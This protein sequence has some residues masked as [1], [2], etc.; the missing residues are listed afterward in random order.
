MN[1]NISLHILLILSSAFILILNRRSIN[2]LIN[3]NLLVFWFFCIVFQ[4][5]RIVFNS[6]QYS[7][8]GLL[9]TGILVL[10][11]IFMFILMSKYIKILSYEEF[12]DIVDRM[13]INY[14]C[15]ILAVYF[16]FKLYLITKYNLL[17]ANI[18]A[19]SEIIGAHYAEVLLDSLFVYPALGAFFLI[20][21][22]MVLN[23]K[24]YFKFLPVILCAN[25]ILF[26]SIIPGGAR[27]F[28]ASI[29]LF[30]ILLLFQQRQCKIYRPKLIFSIV[31]GTVLLWGISDGY[32]RIRG[33]FT[34]TQR[35]T[36]IHRIVDIY[37]LAVEPTA[38]YDQLGRNILERKSPY[39]L[40]Y[41]I[42]DH[43]RKTFQ[44][45]NGAVFI[46]SISNAIPR[47][48]I[49]DKDYLN[50]DILLS[51]MYGL[52]DLDLG[53]TLVAVLQCEISFIAYLITP[54]FYLLLFSIL[55]VVIRKLKQSQLFKL[56]I[57]GFMFFLVF[58]VEITLTAVIVGVR[59][60]ILTGIVCATSPLFL[61]IHYTIQ[62]LRP[63][64]NVK[65]QECKQ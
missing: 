18:L 50:I 53:P 13:N 65:N 36:E 25:F 39:E 27:R 46:Q 5:I 21:A 54:I 58:N 29:I 41:E 38:E 40:L 24:S 57:I 15:T 42:T 19:N 56:S 49:T 43:Q 55:T 8:E 34:L 62:M 22:K 61:N 44:I 28:A 2:F 33:N 63:V 20:I 26:Y 37:T 59:N 4:L 52:Y 30:S 45:A 48:F 47:I 31:L 3:L 6:R 64:K 9:I 35:L 11:Y 12:L 60:I 23:F 1:L 14:L 32:Q 16:L 10:I 51:R 7:F 17:A